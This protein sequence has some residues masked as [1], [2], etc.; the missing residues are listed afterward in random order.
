MSILYHATQHN[1]TL[2][3]TTMDLTQKKLSKAEWLT[4][5]IP[6]SENEKEIVQLIKDGYHD[7]NLRVNT[8]QSMMS[9]MKIDDTPENQAYLY[10][11][12]FEKSITELE[13]AY[14]TILNARVHVKTNTQNKSAKMQKSKPPKTA[15]L[16]RINSMEAKLASDREFIFE[17][18]LLSFCKEM[19]K[20]F[21]MNTPKYAFYLYTLTHIMRSSIRRINP[22]VVEFVKRAMECANAQISMRDVLSQAYEF[23]EK[24]PHLLKYEDK[25]LFAHQKELFTIFRQSPIAPKLVLYIAPTGT[26]KTLSPIGLSEGHRVIFI[27]AAR[28]VGLALA[29]S[30]VSAGKRIAIAFGCETADDIRLHYFAASSYTRNTRTGGIGKVDNSVGDKVQIMICDVQS[31]LISMY[32]MLAFSPRDDS[33]SDDENEN[34]DKNEKRNNPQNKNKKEKDKKDKDKTKEKKPKIPVY[35]DEDLITYWDEP[36]ITMDY[37]D[38]PLHEIIHRNWRENRISKM[39]LSSATLPKE[40]EIAETIAQFRQKFTDVTIH[41]ITSYDCKK[42]ISV[43]NKQ[44]KAIVPHLLFRDPIKMRECVEYCLDNRTLLRYFDLR[45]IVRLIDCLH[46]T[47]GAMD[48]AFNVDDYFSKGI[49]DVTMNS[50]KIYYLELLRHIIPEQWGNVYDILE[51]DYVN[52]IQRSVSTSMITPSNYGKSIVRTQSMQTTNIDLNPNPNP[53]AGILLTT[54]D[55]HTLTDGPTIFLAEDVDKIGKFCIQQSNI[56]SKVFNA[57]SEKISQNNVIQRKIDEYSRKLEDQLEALSNKEQ[58]KDTDT[59]MKSKNKGKKEKDVSSEGTNR[60]MDQIEDLRA[61]LQMVSLD[62]LYIPNTVQHQTIWVKGDPTKNAFTPIIPE[63]NVY[64][65]MEL[66]VPDQMKILLILGI[67]MFINEKDANPRYM[68]I[69]KK[70]A[71]MQQLFLILASSDYIYGTNYQFCHGFIGRD[72]E[73]MTQQ[74]TIQA[75]GRI[76]RNQT[77]QEYTVRFREDSMLLQLFCEP[78]ENREAI[79]MSRLFS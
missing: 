68:E 40:N 5:E 78:E 8:T 55:S 17:M 15:D 43:L 65:I 46:T 36:T 49:V 69:M 34:A 77:Q 31:Y 50:I 20:S 7:V 33:D 25:T 28:H 38:H 42:S 54:S 19:L 52:T 47:E 72:L 44:G 70:M 39:V 2:R 22:G 74:K 41:T 37:E 51:K 56:P 61:K 24:N 1:A 21:A 62:K 63:E 26:G 32:Y 45:Q 4:I 6:I 67:G 14:A 75:M 11:Q 10:K 16:I 60:M 71:D 9:V 64:Q 30:A 79:V 35:N 48:L 59:G 76:G 66:D 18:T 12:Y 58:N 3:N 29:K 27:C 13:T 23:I 73:K 53:L 57:I